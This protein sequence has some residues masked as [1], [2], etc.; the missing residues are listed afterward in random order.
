MSAS[1]RIGVKAAGALA[2]LNRFIHNS[3]IDLAAYLERAPD[4]LGP[5]GVHPGLRRPHC[6]LHKFVSLVG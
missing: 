6:D 3:G 5:L 2:L 1:P 4:K